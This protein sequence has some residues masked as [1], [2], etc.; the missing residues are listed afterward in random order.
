MLI[1]ALKDFWDIE[2]QLYGQVPFPL[3]SMDDVVN[4]CLRK[5]DKQEK[6]ESETY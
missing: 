4:E 1:T 2:E 3:I 5:A 6:D